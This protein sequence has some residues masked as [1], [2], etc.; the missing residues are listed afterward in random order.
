MKQRGARPKAVEEELFEAELFDVTPPEER[1]EKRQLNGAMGATLAIG[2]KPEHERFV[3]SMVPSPEP[4]IGCSY[5][6]KQL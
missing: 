2:G 6:W 1:R 3:P 4:V 5:W